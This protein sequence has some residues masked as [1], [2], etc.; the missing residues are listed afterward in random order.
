VR[1]GIQIAEV[2]RPLDVRNSLRLGRHHQIAQHAPDR[3]PLGRDEQVL[4]DGEV[5]EQLDRLEGTDQAATRHRMCH[6]AVQRYA[7]ERDVP[8]ARRV[9][10]GQRVDKRRLAGAVG[11]DQADDLTLRNR[12]R[13]VVDSHDGAVRHAEVDDLKELTHR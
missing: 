7:L 8:A 3:R 4:L 6:L 13:D 5:V 9:I 10:A 2:A 11:S 12:Q 1:D